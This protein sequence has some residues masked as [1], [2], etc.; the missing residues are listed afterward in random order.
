MIS[1]SGCETYTTSQQSNINWLFLKSL[2]PFP[3]PHPSAIV[4][5]KEACPNGKC[6]F[7]YEWLFKLKVLEEQLELY[8]K[9][10]NE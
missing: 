2:P 4:E 7:L 6:Q 10:I 9:G 1:T 3:P 5:L 8:K